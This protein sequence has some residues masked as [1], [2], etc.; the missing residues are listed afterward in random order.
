MKFLEAV[1][2]ECGVPVADVDRCG[3]VLTCPREDRSA[4]KAMVLHPPRRACGRSP[5]VTK[6]FVRIPPSKYVYF[7]PL[8]NKL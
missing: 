5:P 2:P 4:E 3:D 7:P 1:A 8:G 6:A